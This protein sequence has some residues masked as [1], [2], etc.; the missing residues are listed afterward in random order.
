MASSAGESGRLD[1]RLLSGGI[2]LRLPGEELWRRC[3]GQALEAYRENLTTKRRW[4]ANLV[5]NSP[6]LNRL[7]RIPPEGTCRRRSSPRYRTGQEASLEDLEQAVEK[8]P[9][10]SALLAQLA[11]AQF[12]PAMFRSPQRLWQREERPEA[13][14]CGLRAGAIL[15]SMARRALCAQLLAVHDAGA[16]D[17]RASLTGRSRVRRRELC[18]RRALL[19]LAQALRTARPLAE[20]ARKLYLKT[21]REELT[22]V[23]EELALVDYDNARCGKNWLNWRSRAKTGR[24][25]A[26][27]QGRLVHR[28]EDAT[29]HAQLPRPAPINKS[30]TRRSRSMLWPSSWIPTNPSGAWHWRTRTW[31]MVKG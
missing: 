21:A 1:A 24:C 3:T 11:L 12:N 6:T 5:C 13:A 20:G 27:G 9:N 25:R 31:Q 10:D 28:P 23:L 2:V 8:K 7:S 30:G 29:I 22:T 16:P 14:G 17:E 18:R 4:R 26:V 19:S 15:A